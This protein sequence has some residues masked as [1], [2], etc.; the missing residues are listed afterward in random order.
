MIVHEFGVV[1][2]TGQTGNEVARVQT[3]RNAPLPFS[4]SRLSS[5]RLHVQREARKKREQVQSEG[6]AISKVRTTVAVTSSKHGPVAIIRSRSIVGKRSHSA[7]S[8]EQQPFSFPGRRVGKQQ[9]PSSKQQR[10]RQRQQKP[11]VHSQRTT[12]WRQS[13]DC[14]SPRGCGAPQQQ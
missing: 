3:F 1:F 7:A 9:S 14:N 5:R 4:S 10:Q 8:R 2:L 11:L 6:E 13:H 12:Q